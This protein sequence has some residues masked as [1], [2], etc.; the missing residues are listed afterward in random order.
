MNRY[1]NYFLLYDKANGNIAGF[2]TVLE[3]CKHAEDYRAKL[4]QMFILP[5]YQRQ[6]LGQKFCEV[7]FDY[8]REQP[9]CS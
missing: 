3:A 7:V 6:G 4:S 1:W 2:T 8:Y 9:F 5:T